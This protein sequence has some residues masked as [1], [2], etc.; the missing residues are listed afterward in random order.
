MVKIS[1][2]V[3]PVVKSAAGIFSSPFSSKIGRIS[4]HAKMQTMEYHILASAKNLPGHI[5][6]TRIQKGIKK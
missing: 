3:N 2:I 4:K 6:V 5:L 1:Y